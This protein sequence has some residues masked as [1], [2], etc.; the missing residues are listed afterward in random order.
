MRG[1]GDNIISSHGPTWQTYRAVI[2]PGLQQKFNA[3]LVAKNAAQLCRL[4]QQA[5]QKAGG[6][7]ITVQ[8]LLQ[9][10]SVANCSEVLLN[11]K[12]QVSPDQASPFTGSTTL[13]G[14]GDRGC[15]RELL[16]NP[17]C[18]RIVALGI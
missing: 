10:Y 1:A 12:L 11:M 9:R 15:L 2:K 14:S 17:A 7:G 3:G 18:A 4:I 8:D 13:D 5:T 6:H 16:C